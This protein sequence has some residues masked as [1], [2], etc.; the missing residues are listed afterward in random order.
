MPT[1]E[2]LHEGDIKKTLSIFEHKERVLLY[3]VTTR[4]K[5][6]QPRHSRWAR[7]TC[8]ERHSSEARKCDNL[9]V[10]LSFFTIEK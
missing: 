3:E 6:V 5:L 8:T 2:A 9:S 1:N 10:F 7:R 4:V